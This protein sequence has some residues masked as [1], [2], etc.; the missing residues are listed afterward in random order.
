MKCQDDAG[1]AKDAV[2]TD[3]QGWR[4]CREHLDL[5]QH[6]QRLLNAELKR[7]GH[8]ELIPEEFRLENN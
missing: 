4:L 3:I 7:A 2:G 1:C 5:S 8:P 6:V